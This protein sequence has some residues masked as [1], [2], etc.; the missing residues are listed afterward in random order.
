MATQ[1][2]A[3]TSLI[4]PLKLR[5]YWSQRDQFYLKKCFVDFFTPSLRLISGTPY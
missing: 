1:G 2:A 4:A 3:V 5:R